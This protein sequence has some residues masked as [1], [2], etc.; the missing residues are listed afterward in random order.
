MID[1]PE[2]FAQWDS[3]QG[4]MFL[5][6]QKGESNLSAPLVRKELNEEKM[7]SIMLN[8]VHFK[9]M[10][11]TLMTI[12][13]NTENLNQATY[14]FLNKKYK[15]ISTFSVPHLNSYSDWKI[16]AYDFNEQKGDFFTFV[17]KNL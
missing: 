10:K 3:A 15:P 7:D 16:P 4:M 11:Q 9:K 2:P 8:V 5:D 13:V 1:H 12:Q 14:A 6:W 17:Q